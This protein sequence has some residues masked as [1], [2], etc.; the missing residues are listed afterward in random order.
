MNINRALVAL[1]G[2]ARDAIHQVEAREDLPRRS[3]QRTE[4]LKLRGRQINILVADTHGTPGPINNDVGGAQD[5][6]FD[7]GALGATDDRTDT[8][9]QLADVEG[10]GDVIV[11]A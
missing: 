6:G 7:C 9:D 8:G 10:L 1:K 4:Q 11:S 3:H 5:V 2:V